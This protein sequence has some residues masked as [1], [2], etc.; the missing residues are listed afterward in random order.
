MGEA[1]KEY[2]CYDSWNVQGK[3][4]HV[5]GDWLDL[6]ENIP[7]F[8]T[9]QEVGGT[10][11]LPCS[12]ED[13]E[14]QHLNEFILPDNV[15]SNYHVL[16]TSNV[17]S[18][19][20]QMILLARDSIDYIA[21]TYKGERLIGVKYMPSSTHTYRW[22]FSAHLPHSDNSDAVF[23]EALTELARLCLSYSEEEAIIIGDF[24][25]E[26]GSPRAVSL[27]A[28]LQ[29]RG[30]VCFRSG[31]STRH[32][33]GTTSEIDYAYISKILA[34][35]L[36]AQQP[37]S[38][39]LLV[40]CGSR[41]E[42]GSDH[43]RVT[44][45][46]RLRATNVKRPRRRRPN[47][48]RCGRWSVGDS[49]RSQAPA[50]AA[51]FSS[52]DLH[53]KW[54]VLRD[55]QQTCSFPTPSQKYKDSPA[56]KALCKERRSCNEPQRR[57]ELTQLILATRR[58]ER[59]QWL[60]NLES[61]AARGD[62]H[63]IGY[64]KARSKIFSDMTGIIKE[65]GGVQNAVSQVKEHFT[66]LF[67]PVIP[68]EE[69]QTVQDVLQTLQL[70]TGG[71]AIAH[72]SDDEIESALDKGKCG[73]T[74]GLSGVSYE[75]LHALWS[76]DDGR[77]VLR[78]F[79]QELYASADHPQDLYCSFVTLIPKLSHVVAPKD[80]RPINL[81]EAA[82]KLY[83]RLLLQRLAPV[84]KKPPCQCG[85]VSGGQVLDALATAHWQ[86]YS[87]SVSQQQRVWF[88]A[89]IR[90]AFDT[91]RHSHLATWINEH[92]P[93]YM[94]REALQLLRVVLQPRLVFSWQGADWQLDQKR[95]IQQGHTYSSG[96][97]SHLV[98]HVL[99]QEFD[100]WEAEGFDSSVGKWG[101]LF[102]DDL[103]LHFD[104]WDLAV[105]LLPRL[106]NAFRR[107]GLQFN[108][109]KT[110]VMAKTDMLEKG[111]SMHIPP[112]HV[113][114]QVPWTSH[115]LYLRKP[116]RHLLPGENLWSIWRPFIMRSVH[117][118]VQQM[119]PVLKG[120][121]WL[122]PVLAISVLNRYIA[123]KWLWIAPIVPPTAQSSRTVLALQVTALQTI[124]QLHIPEL[125]QTPQ[126]LALHRLRKRA[127][128]IFMNTHVAQNWSYLWQIRLWSYMGHVL[129]KSPESPVRSVV[130]AMLRLKRPLGG[131]PNSPMDWVIR[132]ASSVFEGFSQ[133]PSIF[134]Y[135][136]DRQSWKQ[137]GM[138]YFY[139][140]IRHDNHSRLHENTFPRWQD[141][142]LQHASWLM[143]FAVLQTQ[144]GF[145]FNWVDNTDGAMSWTVSQSLEAELSRF[146]RH[147][148]MLYPYF[149][150][151]CSVAQDVLDANLP[152]LQSVA[153]DVQNTMHVVLIYSVMT[154]SCI[155][156]LYRV[157]QY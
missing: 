60:R 89:D 100:A 48:A 66:Q 130:N 52:L 114:A 62:T 151:H 122:Q 9:L 81:I 92:T 115:T 91:V 22:I 125:L 90:S 18:Y 140:L 37:T 105:N 14:N 153:D 56:L 149:A 38:N 121:N 13:A 129:R 127:I 30:F 113:L 5:L 118:G 10:G 145:S 155:Q 99:Q 24:N 139:D 21:D 87:G 96:V 29:S 40:H 64:L 84:W 94:A 124:M 15:L 67:H 39:Y 68:P 156:R 131:L 75:L 4:M 72:F 46:L 123:S 6:H 80:V 120:L 95:G 102:V 8:L 117:H 144:D 146:A 147:A 54:E 86:V 43:E 34:A 7:E 83:C 110:Q 150:L 47:K 82:N 16:G 85:G 42:I 154:D 63:A 69:Q 152:V 133:P 93:S 148:R 35:K 27:D 128:Y 143:C 138:N 25:A 107:C 112:E 103:L 76:L 104:T 101:W 19:L 45:H 98:G 73:K 50:A 119:I 132:T 32:G 97:F 58:A 23:E 142:V 134:E 136:F 141:T 2:L 36:S 109:S 44:L 51:H 53:G 28:V 106:Q 3:S 111:C 108:L 33:T 49:I 74:T 26:H 70:E 12:A 61:S 31:V 17:S 79:L 88:N 41:S 65:A 57:L 1:S 55:L 59:F 116:L 78:Q 77:R 137:S 135:A 71:H 157:F 11:S 126:A 20:A